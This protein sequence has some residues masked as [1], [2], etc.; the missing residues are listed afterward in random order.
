MKSL[1]ASS[2]AMT[3]C[4]EVLVSVRSTRSLL[5][6]SL[7]GCLLERSSSERNS[8][9]L[10]HRWR[11]RTRRDFFQGLKPENT[12][13]KALFS[14]DIK[15]DTSDLVRKCHRES[16]G[17]GSCFEARLLEQ[18]VPRCTCFLFIAA[19]TCGFGMFSRSDPLP[20]LRP[21]PRKSIY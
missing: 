21:K 2:A 5:M 9:T 1:A 17:Q 13:F 6:I 3:V 10:Q 16:K 18:G 15:S 7:L 14:S 20:C 19:I 11:A 4:V 12:C 8:T